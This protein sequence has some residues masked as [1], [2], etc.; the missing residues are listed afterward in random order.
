MQN[1]EFF[2]AQFYT[3]WIGGRTTNLPKLAVAVAIFQ[4]VV[5]IEVLMQRHI[6]LVQ[7]AGYMQRM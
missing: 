7:Q 5:A 1:L 4:C 3:V 2:G 6:S